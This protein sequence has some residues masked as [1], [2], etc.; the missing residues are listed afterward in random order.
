[1][2]SPWRFPLT[3]TRFTEICRNPHWD[4]KLAWV[5]NPSN[6]M[7][8][9]RSGYKN[10]NRTA[11]V[12][13][14]STHRNAL[15]VVS[16]LVMA[17]IVAIGLH[18][19]PDRASAY[20][21]VPMFWI[22]GLFAVAG[23]GPDK[24]IGLLHVIVAAVAVRLV[25]IG[26][27]PLLS[28][29]VFRYLWEGKVLSAGMNPFSIAPASI[30]GL[31]D[32][33]QARVNHPEIPSIYPPLALFWF[34]TMS[35]MGGSVWVAQTMT[36]MLDVF[37]A[38]ALFVGLK[39]R[40]RPAHPA[41]IYAL[42][43][44]AAVESAVSA[45]VDVLALAAM[46]WAWVALGR[47]RLV[48]SS[49]L[50]ILGVGAKLLP[51][52]VVPWLLWRYRNRHT[53]WGVGAG[54]AV[55]AQMALP[56][57]NGGATL[58]AGF[59][60]YA[61][62]WQFNGF[63]FP[64]ANQLLGEA[65]RPALVLMGGLVVGASTLRAQRFEQVWVAC[66]SAFILLSPTVHPWY[67]LWAVVPSLA[68]GRRRWAGASAAL[69]GGYLVLFTLSDGGWREPWWL[70]ALT[71]MPAIAILESHSFLNGLRAHGAVSQGEHQDE[72]HGE[73]RAID[74]NNAR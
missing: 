29:D 52:L 60:T 13:E 74:Q 43:P 67:V 16:C 37:V 71:W 53:W 56:V 26:T 19:A 27:P 28:D 21:L 22:W 64:W 33:L 34:R 69:M 10:P 24:R 31:D 17:I 6:G 59:S 14:D 35:V 46:A 11:R 15:A 12:P 38:G 5:Y 39:D 1:M 18:L 72:R 49:M 61:A 44:T 8:T 65:T 45:H 54:T 41:L 7:S 63:A 40:E 62:T 48:L 70:W 47:R 57:A 25:L 66:S 68:A 4:D 9:P 20:R 3:T 50:I 73:D 36:A 55:L 42:L 2:S 32:A 58:L 30:S 51:I 23:P